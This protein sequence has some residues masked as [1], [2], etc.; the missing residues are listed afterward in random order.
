MKVGTQTIQI[1]KKLG[2][3]NNIVIPGALA[4]K[5]KL[6]P[7]SFITFIDTE[8][9]IFLKPAKNPVNYLSGILKKKTKKTAMQI[10]NDLKKDW[11]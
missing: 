11:Q 6:E 5:H 2:I 3:K 8:D 7:N 4:K 1:K 10:K 9:G